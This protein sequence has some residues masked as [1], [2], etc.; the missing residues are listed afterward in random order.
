[1]KD[2]IYIGKPYIEIQNNKAK[3]C[4]LIRENDTEKVLYYEVNE[5]YKDCL[6]D[7]RSDCFLLGLLY[8]AMNLGRNIVCESGVT[9]QL[10]FQLKTYF[11]PVVS[12][13]MPDLK[14]IDIIAEP[15]CSLNT[16]G[17]AVGTGNSGGID[18][19]YTLIKYNKSLFGNFKLTHIIFNNLSTADRDDYRIRKLFERDKI[20][21]QKIA[22]ELG[23][24]QINLYTNLY[25]FYESQ[26]IFNYYFTPQY[27][28]AIYALGKL[29]HIYYYSSGIS[30]SDF[31]MDHKKIKDA[32]YYDTFT[33]DCV[34]TDFLKFYSA[35]SE[36]SR[37]E[38]TEYLA[39]NDVVKNHL[40]VCAVEQSSYFYEN[41]DTLLKR[42]NCGKCGKCLRTISTL[43]GLG[44]LNE[45]EDLFD[46][47]YFKKNKTKFLA[48][49]LANDAEAFLSE[50]IPL[51]KKKNL[52]P[53]NSIILS[54][55]IKIYKYLRNKIS[56]I[57]ILRRLYHNLKRKK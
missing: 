20:E 41:N 38:K 46:L 4:S 17:K 52:L 24:K 21:K 30:V 39:C 55:F 32:A 19:F 54:Y 43:Y 27:A 31:C 49:E 3:L 44:C 57:G 1:M 36:V 8:N 26:F 29:F 13:R 2:E 16:T 15:M 22:D 12:S 56:R 5:E 10:L 35:G 33:L 25:S 23:L 37:L 40:Q 9:E 51:L 7:D 34:S 50:I 48:L 18:S 28:S 42:L 6:V 14:Y 47:E 11:I 53:L 45:Y